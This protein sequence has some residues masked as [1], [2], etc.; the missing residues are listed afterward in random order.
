MDSGGT[1]NLSARSVVLGRMRGGAFAAV[2]LAVAAITVTTVAP[3]NREGLLDVHGTQIHYRE[4]GEPW[5]PSVLLIH[6]LYKDS[7]HHWVTT[8]IAQRLAETHRVVLFDLRGHGQSDRPEDVEA[9]GIELGRDAIALLDHLGIDRAHL[10]GFSLGGR[11]VL[12]LM[13]EE[14][15]RVVTGT[16]VGMGWDRPAE[17]AAHQLRSDRGAA[18]DALVASLPHLDVYEA[19]L[20]EIEVPFSVWVGESDPILTDHVADLRDVRPD[21]PIHVIPGVGHSQILRDG[22][23]QEAIVDHLRGS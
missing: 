15:D 4:L 16:L 12:H 14:P 1:R 11:V 18:S 17:E 8:G 3:A 7:E 9:Y 22:R 6:G 13:A 21:V 5:G 19:E 20:A 23:F 10:V 2:W